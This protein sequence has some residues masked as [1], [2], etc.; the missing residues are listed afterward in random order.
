VAGRLWGTVLVNLA[1]RAAGLAVFLLSL[2]GLALLARRD[3]PAALLLLSLI[4]YFTLI[5]SFTAGYDRYRLPLDP[6]LAGLCALVLCG[7]RAG[8][9]FTAPQKGL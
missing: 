7:E 3:R 1:A 4:I 9:I 8:K 2:Y 5:S 6:L